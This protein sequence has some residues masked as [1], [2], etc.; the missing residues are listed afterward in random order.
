MGL[1]ARALEEAGIATTLTSWNAGVTRL[2]M[3][4]RAT[5]T[6]LSRGSTLGRPG[7]PAQQRR[8]LEATLA[9]LAQHA[10]IDPVMM[11]EEAL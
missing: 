8:V 9:L 2:T 5:F 11:N 3:P 1:T 4:P 10:P 6:R 7:D